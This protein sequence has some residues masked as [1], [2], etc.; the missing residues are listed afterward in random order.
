MVV[1]R[2]NILA[3]FKPVEDSSKKQLIQRF[4][5]LDVDNQQERR[6]GASTEAAEACAD[7]F[8]FGTFTGFKCVKMLRLHELALILSC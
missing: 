7:L 1:D 8:L 5:A 3:D 4:Y 2:T 6:P